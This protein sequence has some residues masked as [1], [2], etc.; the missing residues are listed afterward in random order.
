M[1]RLAYIHTH[2]GAP[3]G[4][5][6]IDRE[7]I[8][9]TRRSIRDALQSFG[10]YSFGWPG[11]EDGGPFVSTTK[12]WSKFTETIENVKDDIDDDTLFLF[13]YFGHAVVEGGKL[14]ISFGSKDRE[15]IQDTKQF[16]R[17]VQ[18]LVDNGVK[19]LI[20]VLDCCH[21]GFADM[22][23]DTLGLGSPGDLKYCVLSASDKRYAVYGERG[24]EWTRAL[25]L[26][27]EDVY[28]P[29]MIN[30]ATKNAT[31]KDWFDSAKDLTR[32]KEL[33]PKWSTY[34]LADIVLLEA[35]NEIDTSVRGDRSDRTIYNRM[36]LILGMLN[37]SVGNEEM[38]QNRMVAGGVDVF[39]ISAED[40]D[41]SGS[42]YLSVGGIR[43][44]LNAAL[45]WGV[46]SVR[47][48]GFYQL[49]GTG[50]E[51]FENESAYYNKRLVDVI[52]RF[53]STKGVDDETL[54]A[55]MVKV[56]GSYRAMD[57]STFMRL[58]QI[59][60]VFSQRVKDAMYTS[61]RLLAQC[62]VIGKSTGD[63]F[64][65]ADLTVDES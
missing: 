2:A 42:G 28:L 27:C 62:G 4:Q 24:G 8:L 36:F 47:E 32:T 31:V 64:Y 14:H 16:G 51:L 17:V 21:A 6:D 45:H 54:H 59:R 15:G 63:V 40:E 25:S 56:Y 35:N 53:M 5:D 44:Y 12:K 19:N 23:A 55:S 30:K 41:G 34:G 39:R 33:D 50:K 22:S 13:Y 20:V 49:T 26:A 37:D 18:E 10:K 52:M 1:K 38:L 9:S 58:V 60:G 29:D 57:F 3:L 61:L 46:V 65:P 43:R 11:K 7:A 48:S